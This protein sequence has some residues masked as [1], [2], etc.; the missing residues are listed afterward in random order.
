MNPLNP[1]LYEVLKARFG[2]VK[3]SDAGAPF[4]GEIVVEN[5]RRRFKQINGGEQYNV[6]CPFCDDTKFKL[7]IG[8]RWLTKPTPDTPM[9]THNARCHRGRGC[10][11]TEFAFYKEFLEALE[12]SD[13][14]AAI[15]RLPTPV[16]P[17]EAVKVRLPEGLVPLDKLPSGHPALQFLARQYKDLDPGYLA[18]HYGA[19]FVSTRDPY[20]KMA[21]ERIIFPI[22]DG[23]KLVAW[24]GRSIEPKPETKWLFTT[25]FKKVWYRRDVIPLNAFPIIAEGITSSIACGPNGTCLFGKSVDEDRARDMGARWR[26]CIIAMDPETF[27][28][29]PRSDGKVCA[30]EVRD[31]LA[32]YVNGPIQMIKWPQE[33]LDTAA[34]KLA[35]DAVVL[36][37]KKKQL[38]L[39]PVQEF[40]VLDPA[41]LGLRGMADLLKLV[42]RKSF[43]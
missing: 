36:Y 40:K 3:V 8:H 42:P 13:L 7:G 14:R 2:T 43:L 32:K 9:L 34:R 25:G 24:Q 15:V 18:H 31:R 20:Y 23:G 4:R 41:D 39:P 17:A 16:K 22:Y 12:D 33:V 35:Y 10:P 19:A 11:V 29:D 1:D 28:P 21:F 30:H 26:G 5:G 37:A 27:L 38:P 6:C